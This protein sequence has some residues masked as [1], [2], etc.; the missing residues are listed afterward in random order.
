M[1]YAYIAAASFFAGWSSCFALWRRTERHDIRT[2][3]AHWAEIDRL[4]QERR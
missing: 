4:L 2:E 3:H 1:I